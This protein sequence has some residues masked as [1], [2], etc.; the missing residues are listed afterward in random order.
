V[1]RVNRQKVRLNARNPGVTVVHE[2]PKSV[3][4]TI[5][6]RGLDIT[7][8]KRESILSGYHE[9]QACGIHPL[10]QSLHPLFPHVRLYFEIQKGGVPSVDLRER[11]LH[12]IAFPI[13]LTIFVPSSSTSFSSQ[14]T[15][16]SL[17][18]SPNLINSQLQ[19]HSGSSEVAW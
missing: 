6:Q 15:F 13:H 5:L 18:T 4:F 9:A 12:V 2:S 7:K 14:P 11:G 8:L 3:V 19:Q 17:S 10:F 16:N 1:F